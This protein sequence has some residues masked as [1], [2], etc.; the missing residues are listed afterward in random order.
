[1]V[2]HLVCITEMSSHKTQ[3]S[4]FIINLPFF[5]L[6]YPLTYSSMAIALAV[7][8]FRPA[9]LCSSMHAMAA[10]AQALPSLDRGRQSSPHAFVA[11][12]LSPVCGRCLLR[13][14]RL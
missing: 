3:R 6:H 8:V 7:S 1:M 4:S 10:S 12:Q 5:S 2:E 13:P 14:V 11:A 9:R